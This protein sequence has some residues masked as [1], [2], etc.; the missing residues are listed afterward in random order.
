MSMGLKF[1]SYIDN[2]YQNLCNLKVKVVTEN[3]SG[4]ITIFISKT[5]KSV[6]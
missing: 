5:I 3:N 2:D 1:Y 4:F 6:N